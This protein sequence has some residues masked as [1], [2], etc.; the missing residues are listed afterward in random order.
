MLEQIII[1][2]SGGQGI[3]FCGQLL[4]R[5]AVRQGLEA[6]YVPSYG[7][8]RRGG[9]SFCSVVAADR[10]I[11]AS[12]FKHPD[13]FLALDQRARNQYASSLLNAGIMLVNTDLAGQPATGE[14]ARVIGLSASRLAEKINF[15][16]PPLNLVM[17]GA[18]LGLDRGVSIE[19]VRAELE[20]RFAG[21]PDVKQR[22]LQAL[23]LGWEEGRSQSR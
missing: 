19:A 20:A 4:A 23:D 8:E 16:Q 22:N 2:G 18:Y 11:Y 14:Q 10:S 1:A 3:Q 5:A 21:K 6:T 9:P 13:I 15:E 12:L 17:L 7:A